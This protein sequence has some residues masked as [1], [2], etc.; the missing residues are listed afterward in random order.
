MSGLSAGGGGGQ[1]VVVAQNRLATAVSAGSFTSG[2]WRTRPISN[3]VTNLIGGSLLSNRVTLPAGTYY[4]RSMAVAYLV[5]KHQVRLYDVTAAAVLLDH[6]LGQTSGASDVVQFPAFV[7]GFFTLNVTSA[8]ELQHRCQ[9]T[10]A[11]NGFGDHMSAMS[12]AWVDAEILV[13]SA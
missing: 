9:T 3:L 6:G 1:P 12:A 5:D 4:S 8:I 13:W 7:D 11:T 10:K 2:A